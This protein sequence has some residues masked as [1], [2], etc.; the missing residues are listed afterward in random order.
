MDIIERLTKC[1]REKSLAVRL[2]VIVTVGFFSICVGIL[3][4]KI[5]DS[6]FSNQ[7][8]APMKQSDL[9]AKEKPVD[10][11][12]SMAYMQCKRLV[13]QAL[14]APSTA[15]FPFLDRNISDLGNKTYEVKSYVDAKNSFGAEIRSNWTC[16]LQFSGGDPWNIDSW[17]LLD[18][19]IL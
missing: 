9:P 6:R 16:K 15:N 2:G 19:E 17:K 1:Y 8:D 4:G 10:A 18:I 3:W 14:K 11:L 13:G 5:A 7:S 12:P